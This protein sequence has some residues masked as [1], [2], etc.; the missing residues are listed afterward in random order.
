MLFMAPIN[1]NNKEY[2]NP[3]NRT[4]VKI[5]NRTAVVSKRARNHLKTAL[6]FVFV[7][8]AIL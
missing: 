4:K 5:N 6:P 1:L 3:I 7:V 8:K 2:I